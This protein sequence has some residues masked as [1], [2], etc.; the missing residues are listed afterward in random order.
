LPIKVVEFTDYVIPNQ[1]LANG[2]S[3]P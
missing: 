1:A 2:S 3:A